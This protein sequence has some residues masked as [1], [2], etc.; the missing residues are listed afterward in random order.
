MNIRSSIKKV[1]RKHREA[2]KNIIKTNEF[3]NKFLIDKGL[4]GKAGQIDKVVKE[5]EMIE[6][7]ALEKIA[8]VRIKLA[9]EKKRGRTKV[10]DP[11]KEN[12]RA[13]ELDRLSRRFNES[14]ANSKAMYSKIEKDNH[15]T[16]VELDRIS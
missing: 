5:I 4:I 9:E 8:A 14:Q 15:T 3:K 12:Q 11:I 6:E 2:V 1:P 16:S 13:I 10:F 7:Y